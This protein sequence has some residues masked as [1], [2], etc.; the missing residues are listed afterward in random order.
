MASVVLVAVSIQP[1]MDA[2]ATISRTVELVSIVSI[3]IRTIWRIDRVRYQMTPN[4]SAQTQAAIAPSVAVKTPVVI[5]PISN[6]GVS[7][8]STASKRK[9]QSARSKR[10]RATTKVSGMLTS[11]W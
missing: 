11:N 10:P 7:I 1:K 5:P 6:T 4:A 3:V 9:Y 8:G 2:A